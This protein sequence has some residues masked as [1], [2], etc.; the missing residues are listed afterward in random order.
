VRRIGDDSTA[1]QAVQNLGRV[2]VTIDDL[3]SLRALIA[4]LELSPNH[5]SPPEMGFKGG[6][7]DDAEE[8]VELSDDEL[9]SIWLRSPNVEI[10]LSSEAATAM[11][12]KDIVEAVH[13]RWARP[14]Q[15]SETTKSEVYQKRKLAFGSGALAA[16]LVVAVIV[17]L[18]LNSAQTT[19]MVDVSPTFTIVLTVGILIPLMLLVATY[20]VISRP[21]SY[22]IIISIT[23]NDYRA[24]RTE[25]KKH[26]RTVAMM[27]LASSIALLGVVVTLLLKK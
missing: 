23:L 24:N 2:L 21:T 13:Q 19:P 14:R 20:R 8:L 11:G 25:S 15:T 9:K 22:A 12:R 4:S 3:R 17:W 10:E 26:W 7:F 5:D 6:E 16:V 27:A 1:K 18:I